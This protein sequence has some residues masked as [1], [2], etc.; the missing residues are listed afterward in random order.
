MG[1]CYNSNKTLQH[2]HKM[3]INLYRTLFL[4][5]VFF[6]LTTISFNIYLITLCTINVANGVFTT[7]NLRGVSVRSN[8]KNYSLVDMEEEND[9]LFVHTGEYDNDQ[10]CPQYYP[11][12]N[13]ECSLTGIQTI[14]CYYKTDGTLLESR[15]YDNYFVDT[16]YNG[17]V[18]KMRKQKVEKRRTVPNE[19]EQVCFCLNHLLSCY[20]TSIQQ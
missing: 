10:L 4:N 13:S 9:K 3:I 20:S 16:R 5:A 15:I 19:A 14:N 1:A 2:I 7:Q 18:S 8:D 12:T 6:L 11:G 17:T